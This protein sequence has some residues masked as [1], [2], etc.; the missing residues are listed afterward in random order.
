MSSAI[1][2]NPVRESVLNN[3]T[4]QMN[5]EAMTRMVR[6]FVLAFD[7]PQ[8]V[9]QRLTH[10]AFAGPCL[11]EHDQKEYQ[12]MFT[13]KVTVFGASWNAM[14]MQS[15]RV[16]QTLNDY[17]MRTL[18]SPWLGKEPSVNAV[19]EELEGAALGVLDKG[20]ELVYDKVLANAKHLVYTRL[21]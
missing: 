6:M 21:Q 8:I 11:S 16:N 9:T 20:L 7:V 17:F 2:Q 15:L 3:H 19:A 12:A 14:F 13:E 18:W 5:D 4:S 10:M 1:Q